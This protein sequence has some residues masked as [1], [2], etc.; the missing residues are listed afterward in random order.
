MFCPDCN[1]SLDN[2]PVDAPCPGCGG[3][4]RSAV[5]RPQTV[6]ATVTIPEPTITVTRA[7][8]PPWFEKWW[9]VVRARD[10]LDEVYAQR[11]P[12]VGNAE[13]DE[14]VTRFCNECHDMR[15]WLIGDLTGVTANEVTRHSTSSP[16]L[17]VSSAVANSHKHHTRKFG[18]T[19][20]RIRETRMTPRGARVTIEVDWATPAAN[21]LDALALANDCVASWRQFFARHGL[22]EPG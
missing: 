1:T 21:T 2:V 8:H 15:D 14:R 20:A 9:E 10:Q 4:R 11:V 18:T 13:V 19:T 3:G 17:V 5:A 7:D 12:A 6:K 22:V 16:A